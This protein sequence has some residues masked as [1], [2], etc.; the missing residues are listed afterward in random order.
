MTA[1]ALG[2]EAVLAGVTCNFISLL[3]LPSGDGRCL[4][5]AAKTECFALGLECEKGGGG[6]G[7]GGRG[8]EG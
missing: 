1:I 3:D 4:K 6:G 5:V 8:G 2:E 7:G